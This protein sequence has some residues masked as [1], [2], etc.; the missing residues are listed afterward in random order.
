MKKKGKTAPKQPPRLRLAPP[1][2]IPSAIDLISYLIGSDRLLDLLLNN[3]SDLIVVLDRDGKRIYN[4]PS[5]RTVLGDPDSLR[6]TSAFGEIHP[7]DRSHIQKI[8]LQTVKTGKGQKATY[9]FLLPGGAIRHIESRGHIIRDAKGEI[10]YILVI[11]RDI[12]AHRQAREKLDESEATF[13]GLVEH[14]LVGVY[15]LQ[16]GL[17]RYANPRFCEMVGYEHE[18]LVDKLRVSDLV[19]EAD[20]ARVEDNIRRRIEGETRSIW[21]SLQGRRKDGTILDAEVSGSVTSFRGK[22]A[23]IGTMLDVTERKRSEALQLALY[24]IKKSQSRNV[25]HAYRKRRRDTSAVQ[26]R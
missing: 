12:T 16:D 1:Q 22:P 21:Y 2:G 18:E 4:S 15:I 9:R 14:S 13:R 24:R 3:V 19:V 23:I 7:E 26:I 5:Y 25:A 8:F 20:R 10:R 17:F 6:G 11:S